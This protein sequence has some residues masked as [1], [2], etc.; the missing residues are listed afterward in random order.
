MAI[1]Q[2]LFIC[3]VFPKQGHALPLR[4]DELISLLFNNRNIHAGT[5]EACEKLDQ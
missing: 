4:A 3:E 2:L 1:E 5:K